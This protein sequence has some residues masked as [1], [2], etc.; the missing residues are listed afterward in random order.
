MG[1][2]GGIAIIAD[3]QGAGEFTAYPDALRFIIAVRDAGI[4][5]AAASSSKN[6]G[7]VLRQIRLDTFA[8]ENG[9][10]SDRVTPGR[11]L[12]E[13]STPI[14]RAATSRRGKPHPEIFLMG[15]RSWACRRRSASSSRTRCPASRRPRREGWRTSVSRAHDEELLAAAEPD[16][17]VTSLDDVDLDAL[18][19]GRLAQRGA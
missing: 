1:E 17:L 7:L 8:E 9:L 16:V 5:V 12:L 3:S 11:T 18:A 14:Y 19:E 10:E 13:P 2:V 4:R 15:P 6:A